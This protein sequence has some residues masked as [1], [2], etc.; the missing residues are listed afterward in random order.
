M[1]RLGRRR[2]GRRDAG[3]T[4]ADSCLRRDRPSAAVAGAAGRA[5]SAD[6]APPAPTPAPASAA[7]PARG[8]PT[9]VGEAVVRSGACRAG[10][11][12]TPRAPGASPARLRGRNGPAATSELFIVNGTK[13]RGSLGKPARKSEDLPA[14]CGCALL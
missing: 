3:V 14:A 12:R 1:L 6:A 7:A 4:A 8:F 10:R 2:R 9:Q 11:A 5:A 13:D